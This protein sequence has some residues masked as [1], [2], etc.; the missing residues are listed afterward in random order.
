[1]IFNFKFNLG[2]EVFS[3]SETSQYVYKECELCKGR[4]VLHIVEEPLKTIPCHGC[5]SNR[6]RPYK[7]RKV[8]SVLDKSLNIGQARVEITDRDV[9][10]YSESTIVERYMCQET[11]VGSGQLHQAKFLFATKEE[12]QAYCNDMNSKIDWELTDAN[13]F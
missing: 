5:R 7:K 6:S 9:H 8:W 4:G 1:M 10:Q 2:Q 11:G 3:V 12:A 13:N